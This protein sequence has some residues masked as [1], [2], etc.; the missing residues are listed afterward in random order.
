[1]NDSDTVTTPLAVPVLTVK[2]ALVSL[3]T[4]EAEIVRSL[5]PFGVGANYNTPWDC[6]VARYLKSLGF[7]ES[8]SRVHIDLGMALGRAASAVC[9][10]RKF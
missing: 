10:G 2:Q 5:A 3:G 6:A 9:T 8:Q 1:M 4:T 7:S